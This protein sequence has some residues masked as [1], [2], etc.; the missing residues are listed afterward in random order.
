VRY[1][2]TA[3]GRLQTLSR[4]PHFFFSAC[5]RCRELV[6]PF[7][8]LMSSLVFASVVST[9]CATTRTRTPSGASIPAFSVEDLTTEQNNHHLAALVGTVVDSASGVALQAAR[10]VV[11]SEDN[12]EMRMAFTDQHGG[13]LLPQLKPVRYKLVVQRV[14]YGPYMEWRNTHAG[15]IDTVRARIPLRIRCGGI[16]CH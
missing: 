4:M 2:L 8:K 16:D 11:V 9:G 10:V 7:C 15:L 5:L 13:F 3:Q 1:I 14:G 12:S 6:R